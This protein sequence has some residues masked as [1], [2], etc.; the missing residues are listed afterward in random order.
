MFDIAV[1]LLPT[2]AR[3]PV[4]GSMS[5]RGDQQG[6]RLARS[7]AAC[8]VGRMTVFPMANHVAHFSKGSQPK[9]RLHHMPCHVALH[10]ATYFK[11]RTSVAV[12]CAGRSGTAGAGPAIL[13]GTRPQQVHRIARSPHCNLRA[14]TALQRVLHHMKT[15]D[16]CAAYMLRAL[17]LPHERRVVSHEVLSIDSSAATHAGGA[18]GTSDPLNNSPPSRWSGKRKT[19]AHAASSAPDC[20]RFSARAAYTTKRQLCGE[21]GKPSSATCAR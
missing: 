14:R 8:P 15:S 13:R 12:G 18:S 1:A 20:E 19:E 4:L 3:T 21:A 10:Y 6:Q 16:R 5:M 17:T 7:Q 9:S 2:A 11:A